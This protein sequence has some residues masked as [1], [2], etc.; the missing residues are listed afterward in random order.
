MVGISPRQQKA[1]QAFS[2]RLAVPILSRHRP[3]RAGLSTNSLLKAINWKQK[4]WNASG[5]AILRHGGEDDSL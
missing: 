5:F 3:T 2:F 1:A 4:L